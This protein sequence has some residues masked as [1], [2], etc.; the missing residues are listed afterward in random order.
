MS[1][2]EQRKKD[3]ERKR[4]SRQR[5]AEEKAMQAPQKEVAEAFNLEAHNVAPELEKAFREASARAD[6]VP[7]SPGHPPLSQEIERA[8]AHAST[9]ESVMDGYRKDFSNANAMLRHILYHL[10]SIDASLF[11]RNGR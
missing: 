7:L 5:K 9:V 1:T 3:A 8:E 6:I 11:S 4:L 10:V 2:E